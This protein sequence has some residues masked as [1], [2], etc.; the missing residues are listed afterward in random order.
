MSLHIATAAQPRHLSNLR[1][2][3]RAQG[4]SPCGSPRSLFFCPVDAKASHM[5]S[6]PV[7]SAL[8]TAVSPQLESLDLVWFQ[9]ALEFPLF[10][11]SFVMPDTGDITVAFV[12]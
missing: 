3:Q 5:P 1:Q 10:A 7:Q 9:C 11:A 4:K 2:V 6:E 8:P 12:G